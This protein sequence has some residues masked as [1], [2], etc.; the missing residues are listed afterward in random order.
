MKQTRRDDGIIRH[1]IVLFFIIIIGILAIG[2][3]EA[4]TVTVDAPNQT[5]SAN[6]DFI[7][8]VTCNPTQAIKAYEFRLS[9]DSSLLKVN[10]VTEGNIFNSY[11]TFFNAGTINNNA[12]M[13]TD[14]YSLIVGTGNVTANDTFITISCTAMDNTGTSALDL[15][16]VGITDELGYISISITNGSVK[17][18][19]SGGGGGGPLPPPPGGGYLPGPSE[20]QPPEAPEQPSGPIFIER[21]INYEYSAISD[22]PDGDGIR[23]RFDWGDGTLSNWSEVVEANTSITMT[24]SWHITLTYKIKVIA[25]DE[26]GLNSSWSLP[27]NVTVSQFDIEGESPVANFTI[28]TNLSTKKPIVFDGSLSYDEDGVIISYFW[29]FGDGTTGSGMNP[30]HIYEHS[31]EFLVTLVVTDNNGN[32]CNKTMMISVRSDVHEG[33]TESDFTIPPLALGLIFTGC[34]GILLLFLLIHYRDQIYVFFAYHKRHPIIH[35]STNGSNKKIKRIDEK[36]EKIR[37]KMEHK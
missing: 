9:F 29:I 25:Q 34:G 18:Q 26:N 16:D 23:Y 28:P 21:G 12:G 27:L 5:I 7:V 4:T 2:A 35:H 36:I 3:V 32:T 8:N 17:V 22:D 19:G 33:T 20:N 10:N 14:I 6:Q 24:H 13:I 15:H 30:S 37:E 1:I 11:T 31:G